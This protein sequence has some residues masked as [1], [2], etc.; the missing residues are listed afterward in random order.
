M[1]RFKTGRLQ[2]LVERLGFGRRRQRDHCCR[3]SFL[4][5]LAAAA[6]AAAVVVVSLV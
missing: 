2:N 4:A 6:A 1:H 5:P 3:F